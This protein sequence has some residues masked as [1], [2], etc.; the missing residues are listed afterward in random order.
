MRVAVFDFDGTLYEKET[1]QVL[2][3]HLKNHPNYHRRYRKFFR[4]ML[5]RYV[6]YKL[7]VYPERRMKER[8]MQLYLNSLNQLP[9]DEIDTYFKEI[10]KEMRNHFNPLVLSKLEQHIENGVYVMLVSGAYTNLV[11]FTTKYLNFDKVIG[12]DIIFKNNMIDTSTPAYHING[13]RKNEKIEETLQG[14]E[15]DWKNSYAY[16]DSYSDISVLDLVGN[17]VAVQP[18]SRLKAIAEERNWEIM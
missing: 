13:V 5:P 2:M 7:K 1:F 15:I 12:T 16:A 10:G 8:S 9:K 3:D 17:P 11:Q 6:G 18:D 14:K 4:E